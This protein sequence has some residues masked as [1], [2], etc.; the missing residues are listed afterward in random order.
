MYVFTTIVVF[1]LLL[2]TKI[3][4][5]FGKIDIELFGGRI[6][7]S[8]LVHRLDSLCGKSELDVAVQGLGEES[9]GLEV[10]LLDL[11]DALVR[12]GN[13]AGL[14]VGLL[15]EQ[16]ADAGSHFHGSGAGARNTLRKYQKQS[17]KKKKRTKQSM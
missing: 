16:V 3:T 5:E 15:S 4:L 2:S 6:D 14:S 11:L 1:S 7:S 9:L 17:K 8:H 13:N 10:D 12:E